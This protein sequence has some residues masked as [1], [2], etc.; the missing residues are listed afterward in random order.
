M[1]EIKSN[2][3]TVQ[4]ESTSAALSIKPDED[5]AVNP[6]F[7]EQ[8][9]IIPHGQESDEQ[10]SSTDNLNPSLSRTLPESNPTQ[11]DEERISQSTDSAVTSILILDLPESGQMNSTTKPHSITASGECKK[12]DPSLVLS[13][14]LELKTELAHSVKVMD[15]ERPDTPDTLGFQAGRDLHGA[16]D[17]D[18]C[19]SKNDNRNA[20]NEEFFSGTIKEGME[21]VV[22]P[23]QTIKLSL[24]FLFKLEDGS[25]WDCRINNLLTKLITKSGPL[26]GS[27]GSAF[28]REF[29]LDLDKCLSIQKTD[30]HIKLKPFSD[31]ACERL[32]KETGL[33]LRIEERK[34]ILEG[35]PTSGFDG[36]LVFNIAQLANGNRY[37]DQHQCTLPLQIT[38]PRTLWLDLP[39]MDDEGYPAAN[40][41][42]LG[43]IL[44]PLDK[45]VVAASCRGRSHAHVGKARDDN[46]RIVSDSA[47]GWHFVTVADGAGSATFS[48]KGSALAC[49]AFIA[50][51]RQDLKEHADTLSLNQALLAEWKHLFDADS[52]LPNQERDARYRDTLAL[53]IFMHRAVHAAYQAIVEEA[54]LKGAQVRD[55]HTTLLCAA[56][57]KFPF[58]YFFMCYWV[59][60][61]GMVLYNWNGKDKIFSLGTPDGGDFAG[62]TRFLTMG[63]EE[64]NAQAIKQR[65]QYLFVDNFEAFLI[66]SDGITDPFFPSEKAV[67]EETT[68]RHFWQEILKNGFDDNPGCPELFDSISTPEAKSLALRKWLNF[69]SKGNHDDRTIVVIK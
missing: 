43:Q 53:D 42:I 63:K 25:E 67:V 48:R 59:G 61:G 52:G 6:N 69:W 36:E 4:E 34:V 56:F 19:I 23:D 41:D 21:I 51:L 49:E 20:S 10:T 18:E 39:V 47:S 62:Q 35:S 44:E 57:R 33:N 60:D 1:T 55:Y 15:D 65:T 7:N 26:L 17:L 9:E 22:K 38:D 66:A 50:Q 45:M 24:F 40:E 3:G 11:S 16:S 28:L 27:V 12:Y 31:K 13:S 46:F 5:V 54:S 37:V 32:F 29:E 30:D 2:I 64:I 8:S 68:W 14:D 58:G